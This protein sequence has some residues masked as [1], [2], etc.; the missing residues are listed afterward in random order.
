MEGA[1]RG[2]THGHAMRRFIASRH[3][4]SRRR[5]D[6]QNEQKNQPQET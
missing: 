2:E 4:H 1:F 3:L 6:I 5:L